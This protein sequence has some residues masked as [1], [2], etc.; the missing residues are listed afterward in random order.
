[1]NHG[2]T[3]V[4][5][6]V[7]L[8]PFTLQDQAA[9]ATLTHQPEITDLLPDW[10]MTEEQLSEFLQFVVGSYE[11]FDPQD[12]R[13]M[14]AV[15]HQESQ[16]LIGWCGVF[17]N[18]MLDPSDREVAYA[19]SRDH[20][21]KGYITEAV[22]ALT[23]YLFEHTSLNR[24]VG[25]VKTYNPSS[26]KVLEHT[27]FQYVNRRLLSDGE[28]YDYFELHST[29]FNGKATGRIKPK[30]LS[31]NLR[32]AEH[33]D[34]IVLT[35]ICTRAFD[36]AMQVW[37]NGEQDLDS[38]LCPP[39]YNA[40]RLHEYVIREWDYYVVE[41]D[42]C[43]IGGVSIN[44]LG[45]GIARLDRIYIDPVF[46]GRGVGSQVI[47]QIEAVFP[48]ILHWRLETSSRQT[49][50]HHFYEKLGYVRMYASDAEYGYEKKIVTRSGQDDPIQEHEHVQANLDSMWYSSSTMRNSRI[51]DCN[52]SGSK[53]TNLNMTEM[54]LADLRLTNTKFEFC[55]L[56][57][58]QFQDT[59]LGDDRV[60]M[61]WRHC[62]LGGS[63]FVDCDL[64]GVELEACQVSGMKINGI[65]IEK[66]M[67]AYELSKPC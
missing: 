62:D 59:H 54:L 29:D 8:R 7:M 2:F 55:A 3:I 11:Q 16:Q 66:L 48:H 24:I 5:N 18:D 64:S 58:V 23:A 60:P 31:I 26:R 43:A 12:V 19:I 32:R 53:L 47:R 49:S 35:E 51:T 45:K 56:D 44:V 41:A 57:G 28:V 10:K 27:G 50:N 46:Q 40:V 38:N 14:L 67:E 22:R 13:I 25:I 15:I 33:E 4:A 17:P 21:N 1:M 9:L 63:R 34:A 30:P 39:G 42:G 65:P 20:R 6:S 52:L 37:A 61:Q 36:H